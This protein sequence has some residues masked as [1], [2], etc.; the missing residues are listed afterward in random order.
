MRVLSRR[1]VL[2]LG[3]GLAAWLALGGTSSAQYSCG[4]PSAGHCYGVASW[5]ER[6]EYFGAYTDIQ[7]APMSCAGCDG[8]VDNEIWLIDGTSPECQANRFGVCWVE[9]GYIAL[10]GRNTPVFFWAD[11]PPGGQFRLHLLGPTDP[12]GTV[13]HFMIVK[14]GRVSPAPFLVFIYND[15]LSTLYGGASTT[16][17]SIPMK[18]ERID[19]GQELAGTTGAFADV[20][21]FTRNIW[22]VTPLGPE[23]VFW[24]WPQTTMGFVREDRPP[25]GAW[26]IDPSLPPPPEGGQF[27]THCCR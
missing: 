21:H 7:Q 4:T 1:P 13:D 19:L 10:Q 9:A 8:F 11:M 25:F 20:T 17:T 6:P 22:A 23:Y 16:V 14:D 24:Y 12:V 5:T 15:S 2:T 26:T 27:T 3:L 18:A